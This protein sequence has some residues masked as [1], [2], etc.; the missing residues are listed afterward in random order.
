LIFFPVER[1]YRSMKYLANSGMR[2][3]SGKVPSAAEGDLSE[4]VLRR[5][6]IRALGFTGCPLQ[7]ANVLWPQ[8]AT[9]TSRARIGS[10]PRWILFARC[11]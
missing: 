7:F 2:R 8:M 5:N 1:A 10:H 3:L 9:Q 4:S 11:S 6:P